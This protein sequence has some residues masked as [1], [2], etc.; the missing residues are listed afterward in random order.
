LPLAVEKSST[1][2]AAGS[3]ER[4]KDLY[5]QTVAFLLVTALVTE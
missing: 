2:T 5:S 4:K 1:V 3:A